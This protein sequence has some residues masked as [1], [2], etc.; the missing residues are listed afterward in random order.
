MN[1]VVLAAASKFVIFPEI[2]SN[3]NNNNKIAKTKDKLVWSKCSNDDDVDLLPKVF[4]IGIMNRPTNNNTDNNSCDCCHNDPNNKNKMIRSSCQQQQQQLQQLLP[5]IGIFANRMLSPKGAARRIQT[6]VY[7]RLLEID[8][9]L[10]FSIITVRTQLRKQS[11]LDE[12]AYD[13]FDKAN[14]H[15]DH[16]HDHDHW[17]CNIHNESIKI[18]ERIIRLIETIQPIVVIGD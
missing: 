18:I 2:N 11:N 5:Q 3:S 15:H 14:N 4:Q 9:D 8:I 17:K 1:N 7:E 12:D 13:D 10:V 6:I 16:D